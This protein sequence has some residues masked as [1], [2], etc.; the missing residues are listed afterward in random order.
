MNLLFT[1]HKFTDFTYG[2][3]YSTTVE[4]KYWQVATYAIC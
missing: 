4:L 1:A 3:L 2:F